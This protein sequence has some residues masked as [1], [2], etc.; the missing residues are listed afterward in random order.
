M[1]Q[2]KCACPTGNLLPMP[3]GKMSAPTLSYPFPTASQ[4]SLCSCGGHFA[5]RALAS[6]RAHS[7]YHNFTRLSVVRKLGAA[8]QL[9]VISVATDNQDSVSTMDTGYACFVD[10]NGSLSKLE[11]GTVRIY[12]EAQSV[13][14]SYKE[15]GK[16][17]QRSIERIANMGIKSGLC[18]PLKRGQHTTGYLFL[19]AKDLVY[20][21]DDR[22]YAIFSYLVVAASAFLN[23]QAAL[24]ADYYSLTEKLPNMFEGQ[25][26]HPQ[27]M[28]KAITQLQR[29]V[30]QKTTIRF[31]D[32]AGG[33]LCS[34]GNFAYLIV[35][36]LALLNPEEARVSIDT[37][38]ESQLLVS[39][40]VGKNWDLTG[41]LGYQQLKTDASCLG[42]ELSQRAGEVLLIQEADLTPKVVAD[43]SYSVETED[44]SAANAEDSPA[45]NKLKQAT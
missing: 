18:F 3:P 15:D 45:E 1:L 24:S 11:R 6:L 17:P 20:L 38:N 23:E 16:P 13:V 35:Q 40:A 36:T 26:F 34:Y 7:R 14:E 4:R 41:A 32:H 29:Q 42:M 19:N 31:K 5:N 12:K 8:N 30:D 33:F 43:V 28:Q 22:D 10:P 9:K 39:L 2:Q 21:L 25:A 44:L 27:E 37:W